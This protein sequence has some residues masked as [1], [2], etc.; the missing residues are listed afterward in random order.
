M[1]QSR[2]GPSSRTPRHLWAIGIIALLWNCI[3]AFDYLMTQTR[4][5]AYMSAFPPEQLAWFYGLPAWVVAAW[6]IAVWGGVLGSILL[7]LRRRLAVPV[8]LASLV[9]M[10]VTTF[11]N[12][13]LANAAEVF[14]DT[15]SRVFSVVIFVITVALYFYAR[16]M[17]ERGVLR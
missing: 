3:G 17:R 16:A 6:A 15:F 9:A 5:A 12:W 1:T 10:V 7:L 14:P 13:V 4:N 11:Q 8:F 2:P